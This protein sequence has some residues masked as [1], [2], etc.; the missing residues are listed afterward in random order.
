MA[1]CIVDCLSHPDDVDKINFKCVECKT[2]LEQ[3]CL[4]SRAAKLAAYE[5]KVA[6]EKTK[7]AE[8][9]LTEAQIADRRSM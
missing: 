5:A 6:A 1:E 7:A 2:D 3:A 9:S 8:G 4:D